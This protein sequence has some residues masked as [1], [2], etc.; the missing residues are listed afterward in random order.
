MNQTF[1][2]SSPSL[3][4]MPTQYIPDKP[5]VEWCTVQ[6]VVGYANVETYTVMIAAGALL[7]LLLAEWLN[8][9]EKFKSYSPLAVYF[10]KLTL[11][12]F[13]YIYFFYVKGGV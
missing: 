2:F 12:F 3:L 5:C 6:K 7:L 13:F 1:E 11:Y 8:E 9:H 10:S 4:Q